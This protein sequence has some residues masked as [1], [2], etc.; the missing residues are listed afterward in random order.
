MDTVCIHFASSLL[1][2][3]AFIGSHLWFY[4]EGCAQATRVSAFTYRET[5]VPVSSPVQGSS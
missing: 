1:P 2:P 3:P 4:L 5:K